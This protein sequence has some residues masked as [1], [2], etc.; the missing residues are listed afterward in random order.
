LDSIV[1][2]LVLLSAC[3]GDGH[4]NDNSADKGTRQADDS[5]QTVAPAE[6]TAEPKTAG[7][8]D[9]PGI[10]QIVIPEIV[11]IGP[12]QKSLE[13]SMQ[14]LIDPIAG[15]SVKPARCSDNDALVNDAGVT[16]VDAEGNLTRIGKNDVFEIGADGTGSAVIEGGVF[17]VA[18]D[19]S[20]SIVH[21]EEVIEVDGKGKGRYVGQYGVIELDG[22]GKGTF[23]A[24]DKGEGVIEINGDGSGNCDVS[25]LLSSSQPTLDVLRRLAVALGVSA[26]VLLFDQDER[27]PDEA[28]KLKFE[29]LR[30]FND[31]ERRIVE[32]VLDS[33]IVQHQANRLFAAPAAVATPATSTTVAKK[34]NARTTSK[35]VQR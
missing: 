23:V 17:E 7:S 30:Q 14:E 15:I 13:S 31:D 34:K 21:N 4:R 22:N 19:G 6:P 26:D 20:G 18:A 3:G 29:A 27:G 33:L 32:G 11:G 24:G 9:F 12:A 5:K 35:R 28:L 2:A 1:T 25:P 8:I 16:S 10:P